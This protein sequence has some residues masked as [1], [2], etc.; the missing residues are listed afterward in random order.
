MYNIIDEELMLKIVWE[1][2]DEYHN[3]KLVDFNQI[4]FK[5][6]LMSFLKQYYSTFESADTSDDIGILK[7]AM[8]FL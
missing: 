8:M 4:P 7:R 1:A 2:L 5:K 3:E 6:I